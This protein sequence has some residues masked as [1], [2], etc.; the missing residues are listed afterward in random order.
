MSEVQPILPASKPFVVFGLLEGKPRAGLFPEKQAKLVRKA[1]KQL[2]LTVLQIKTAEEAAIAA[3]VP[4]GRLYANRRIFVPNVRRD[5]H[6]KLTAAAKAAESNASGGVAAG[7]TPPEGGGF[8]KDWDSIAPGHQV[9]AQSS[10]IEG[11]WEAIVLE[12]NGEMLT[13][14][15]RDYPREPKFKQHFEMVALQFAMTPTTAEHQS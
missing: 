5:L 3:K 9:I 1:A 14:R 13:L 4:P 11:W 7:E 10:L 6:E 8:P 2:E 12:R 15:W